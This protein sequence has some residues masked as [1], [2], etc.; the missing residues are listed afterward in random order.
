[1][2]ANT[3]RTTENS[4]MKEHVKWKY[5]DGELAEKITERTYE[6]RTEIIRQEADS[7]LAGFGPN[8]V[9]DVTE[10][11]TITDDSIRTERP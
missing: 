8:S 9:G 4:N 2:R 5:E 7:T 1:M 10:R 3:R 6:D 11:T